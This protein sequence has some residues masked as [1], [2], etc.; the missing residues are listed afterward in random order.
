MRVLTI[1]LLVLI[2]SC[3]SKKTTFDKFSEFENYVNQVDNG[4]IKS[5]ES[6]NLIFET[7]LVPTVDG[8]DGEHFVVHLRISNKDGASV[9]DF[10]TS[11]KDEVLMREGYL[12]FDVIKDAFIAESDGLDHKPTFH[13]YERNYGLK[14]SID[15][16]F[17]FKELSPKD[18]VSFCYRDELFGQGLIK[19]ELEKELFNKC[20]VKES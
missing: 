7:K 1:V 17:K 11:S 5:Q 14:P 12:S 4:Y 8:V 16:F 20:Y 2:V 9:L 13:H 10:G 19:I 15:M 18:D 6:E 3:Q